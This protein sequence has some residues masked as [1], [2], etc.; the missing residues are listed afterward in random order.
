MNEIDS[1]SNGQSPNGRKTLPQ[2]QSP[3]KLDLVE[4]ADEIER[5]LQKAVQHELLI[6]KRLGNPVAVWR[7]G[8]VIVIPPEEIVL[9]IHRDDL[10]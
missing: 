8:K 2:V 3:S 6:H 4:Q 1:G 9:T 5:I 10:S 7:D